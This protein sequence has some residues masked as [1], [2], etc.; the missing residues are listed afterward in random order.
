MERLKKKNKKTKL[1]SER[2]K[3]NHESGTWF[4]AVGVRPNGWIVVSSKQVG[5]DDGVPRDEETCNTE[6]LGQISVNG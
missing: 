5:D 1:Y 2:T 4:E 6:H 3:E